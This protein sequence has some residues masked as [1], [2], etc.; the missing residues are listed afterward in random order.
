MKQSKKILYSLITLALATTSLTSCSHDKD[1]PKQPSLTDEYVGEFSGQLTLNIADQYDYD[2]DMR[3]VVSKGENETLSVTFPDY[4]LSNT[5]M[6][7][8][9]MGNLTLENLTYDSSKG[10]FYL[11]YGEA[12]INQYFKA[13]RNGTVTMDGEYRLNAPSDILVSISEDGKI[14]VVNSFRIGAMPMPITAT[15]TGQKNK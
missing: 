11:N 7:D 9:T 12:G 1:E 13:E 14:T 6:G 3:I 5:L 4:T 8:I 15:F 10:G 2:T